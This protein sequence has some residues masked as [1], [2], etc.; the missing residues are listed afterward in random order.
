MN[1]RHIKNDLFNIENDF[2]I[3]VSA[4]FIFHAAAVICLFLSSFFS[5]IQGAISIAGG[6]IILGIVADLGIIEQCKSLRETYIVQIENY[7]KLQKEY[8]TLNQK[9]HEKQV[10]LKKHLR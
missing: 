1:D 4:S 8:N 10:E 3:L 9:Y 5:D 7:K 6:T 2:F